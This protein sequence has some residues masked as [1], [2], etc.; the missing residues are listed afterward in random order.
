MGIYSFMKEML[1]SHGSYFSWRD[2]V[3]IIFFSAVIYS[4]SVWLKKDRQKNLLFYFY[5]FCLLI[6]ISHTAQLTT[7]THSLLFFSPMV[8]MLFVLIHQRTL[9]KNFVT[10][11]NLIPAER[12]T[13]DWIETLIQTSLIALNNN[14]EILCIIEHNDSLQELLTTPIALHADAKKGLLDILIDSSLFN[15]QEYLWINS[16]G[17]ICG[18]NAHWKLEPEK[19]FDDQLNEIQ[20]SWKDQALFFSAK[21]DALIIKTNSAHRNFDILIHGQMYNA[22]NAQNAL[23]TI[24]KYITS[25]NNDSKKES[26]YESN[27]KKS[28]HQQPDA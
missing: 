6:F 11:R 14:K 17:V 28:T 15:P 22:L 20:Q 24:K 12:H 27:R 1:F 26:Y 5:S 23:Y 25:T 13:S 9:Q 16:K 2:G 21:T 3:E 8:I 4:L 7:I 18:I 19:L 10:L